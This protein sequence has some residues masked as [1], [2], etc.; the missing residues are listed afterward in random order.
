M[1]RTLM[2]IACCLL[3]LGFNLDSSAQQAGLVTDQNPRYENS[4]AKYMNVADSLTRNQGSTIQQ[5]YKA[6]DWYEAREERR[7][8]RRETR[9]NN[10]FYNDSYYGGGNFYPTMRFNNWGYGN[11]GR[12]YWRNGFNYGW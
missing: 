1:K 9:Y 12:S 11:F 6:Y 3:G 7:K 8:L 5:T 10:S 2:T 4:R